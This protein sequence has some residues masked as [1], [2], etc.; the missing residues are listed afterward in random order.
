[1]TAAHHPHAT[2]PEKVE[3]IGALGSE[4]AASGCMAGGSIL[5]ADEVP[6]VKRRSSVVTGSASTQPRR[7]SVKLSLR[8]QVTID[9]ILTSLVDVVPVASGTHRDS[10]Q[11]HA[12][13]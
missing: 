3:K 11:L 9:N 7:Q 10:T 12:S 1:M 6:A 2:L 5:V 8:W 4:D 13:Q